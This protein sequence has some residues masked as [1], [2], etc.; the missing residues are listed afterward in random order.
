MD[1]DRMAA[2]GRR[3]RSYDSKR[4]LAV[5]RGPSITP[6]RRIQIPS[7]TIHSRICAICV[8]CGCLI[9]VIG[10][11]VGAQRSGRIDGRRSP[12]RQIGGEQRNGYKR[13]AQPRELQPGC[14]Y[15]ARQ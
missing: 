4:I 10:G 14:R 6:G 8:I 1:A 7:T 2:D 12:R 15:G 13:G 11:S 9:C 3:Y 5:I